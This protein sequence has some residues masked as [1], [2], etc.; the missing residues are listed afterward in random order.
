MF[1]PRFYQ[2]DCL[3]ILSK[4]RQNGATQALVVMA[5]GLGKTVT[6]AFDAQSFRKQFPGARVLYLCHQNQISNQACGTFEAINGSGCTYG[7]YNSSEKAAHSVDFLFASFQTMRT[8][9]KHFRSDEFDYVVVD[10]SHHT[11]GDTFL[12]VVTYWKPKFLLGVTA[13]PDRTDCQDIRRVFGRE[14]FFLPLEE[15]LAQGL[16]TPVDYRLMTDEIRLRKSIESPERRLSMSMLNRTIFVPRRDAEIVRIIQRHSQELKEPKIIIFCQSVRHTE[17]LAKIMPRAMAIHSRIPLAERLVRTELFRQGLIDTLLTVDCFNEGVDIPEANVIVF[18]RTTTSHVVFFQ[19]LGRGL[20]LSEG[21]DRV[22][23]LDFVG[24]CERVKTIYSLWDEV[25]SRRQK[26]L[27]ASPAARRKKGAGASGNVEPFYLNVGVVDFKEKIL[28]VIDIIRRI[29]D[30]YT[31]DECISMLQAYAADLKRSPTQ[32]QVHRNKQMPS[33]SLLNRYFGNFTGALRAAELAVNQIREVSDMDL[34]EQLRV[35]QDKLGH[36][37]TQPEVGQASKDG[38]CSSEPVFRYRFGSL[39][40]ALKRIGSAS[41]RQVGLTKRQLADQLFK[42]KEKLG[43]CPR[44]EDLND[45][46]TRKETASYG[47][48]IDRFKTWDK[49][50]RAA[51]CI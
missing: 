16:L 21:K 2:R 15:A 12:D 1:E 18:L 29:S 7:Y 44:V 4:A 10:E 11:Y 30:G 5:S 50:L 17:Q 25:K 42:L 24:S 37:P 20:R 9:L 41:S 32:V 38:L 27:S 46:C 8:R 35:L 22:I 31:R 14:V 51:G 34:L 39:N 6:M 40:E 26:V 49:A 23:V 19:Q 43:Y 13:T 48:F 47:V 33:M 36:P 45:A 3:R 28:R